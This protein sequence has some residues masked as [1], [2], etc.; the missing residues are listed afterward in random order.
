MFM[1]VLN[2]SVTPILKAD[3]DK[4]VSFKVTWGVYAGVC[5]DLSDKVAEGLNCCKQVG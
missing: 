2:A 1:L 4:V 5:C 3:A